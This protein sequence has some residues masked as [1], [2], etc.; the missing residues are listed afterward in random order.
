MRFF[1][2]DSQSSYRIDKVHGWSLENIKYVFLIYMSPMTYSF[3]PSSFCFS[4]LSLSFLLVYRC[5]HPSECVCTC[6]MARLWRSDREQP[7]GVGCLLPPCG[8]QGP[9]SDPQSWHHTGPP[10]SLEHQGSQLV[11]HYSFG[12]TPKQGE[13][14]SPFPRII[15][16]ISCMSDI[17]IMIH[18]NSKIMVM[19]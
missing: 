5:A 13:S 18:D 12:D 8:V 11:S 16:Q 14:N 3:L 6:A 15:Y 1:F 4:F 17:Y 2:F 7:A 9:N 19:K 10:S